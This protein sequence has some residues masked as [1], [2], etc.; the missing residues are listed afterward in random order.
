MAHKNEKSQILKKIQQLQKASTRC[1]KRCRGSL[2]LEAVLILPLFIFG[3]LNMYASINY[4]SAHTRIEC[5]MMDCG[6]NLATQ[7]YAYEKFAGDSE[8]LKSRGLDML[9][10]ETYVK[11]QILSGAGKPFLD[12][13][14]I[15]GGSGGVSFIQ[16]KIVS[17][18][19]L[20]LHATY[21]AQ[22]LFLPGFLEFQMANRAYLK[23]WTGYDNEKNADDSEGS[24]QMVY[25]TETGTVYHLTRDCTHIKLSISEIDRS[26]LSD[27][28]NENGAAYSPCEI[29]CKNGSDGQLIY[30]TKEGERY[31]NSISCSG[32][33]RTVKEIPI[34]EVGDRLPC[35]RCGG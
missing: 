28:R 19:T 25:I 26:M 24:E 21:R 1:K 2:T 13:I 10:S 4:I 14:G 33:K 16:S 7:A 9:F 22:A 5:A 23:C 31:H 17:E 6:M 29:C 32:L 15:R 8:A 30:I 12:S 11:E 34:S 27:S 18:D 20:D 3:I 35:S